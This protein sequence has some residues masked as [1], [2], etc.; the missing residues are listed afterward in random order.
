MD[1][2]GNNI[3]TSVQATFELCMETCLFN[4]QCQAFTYD[5]QNRYV[6][7][8]HVNCW[9]KSKKRKYN[10]DFAGFTSG[11]RCDY[12]RNKARK[13]NP[14]DSQYAGKILYFDFW[15]I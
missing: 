13:V 8:M 11:I 10:T 4:S 15:Q 5:H 12:R 6:E 7:S 2:P 1:F 14:P 9:L 3:V